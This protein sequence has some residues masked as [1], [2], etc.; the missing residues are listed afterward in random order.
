METGNY[1]WSYDPRTDELQWWYVSGP[2][3]HAS[4]Q[5]YDVTGDEGYAFCSQGRLTIPPHH[6]ANQTAFGTIYLSRP[7]KGLALDIQ[8]TAKEKLEKL[9]DRPITWTEAQ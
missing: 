6:A 2:E 7:F 5:H 4:P 3:S 9:V 1:K 8:D